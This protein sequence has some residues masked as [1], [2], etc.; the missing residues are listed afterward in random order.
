APW[1]VFWQIPHARALSRLTLLA[2]L[3]DGRNVGMVLVAFGLCRRCQCRLCDLAAHKFELSVFELLAGA[4]ILHAS[5][6]RHLD[7]ELLD[8]EQRDLQGLLRTQHFDAESGVG[9]KQFLR[10]HGHD[11]AWPSRAMP[12]GLALSTNRHW[13]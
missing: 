12:T 1:Q 8:G 13:R 3:L 2:T 7:L 5:Q 6:V 10:G 4:P 9:D 11:C